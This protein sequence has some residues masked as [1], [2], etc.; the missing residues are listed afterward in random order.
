M[1]KELGIANE[2]KYKTERYPSAAALMERVGAGEGNQIGFGQIH[3]I[4]RFFAHGVVVV[5]PLLQE[6]S[7]TMTYVVAITNL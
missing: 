6:L 7:N 3:A 1:V 2:V 4:R 5:G